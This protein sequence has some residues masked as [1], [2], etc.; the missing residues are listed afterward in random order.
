M[1]NFKQIFEKTNQSSGPEQFLLL[2][3]R[4]A[5]LDAPRKTSPNLNHL[6]EETE[7]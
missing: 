5:H 3:Y 6:P 2:L 7:D 1:L 4:P